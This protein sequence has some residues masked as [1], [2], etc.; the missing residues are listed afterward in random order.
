MAGGGEEVLSLM[1]LQ[2]LTVFVFAALCA[3][4]GKV[5]VGADFSGGGALPP[6]WEFRTHQS[7]APVPESSIVEDA[8]GTRFLRISEAKGLSGTA[9][10]PKSRF[11]AQEGDTVEIELV[12]RG[13][14]TFSV[15]FARYTASGAW[16][17]RTPE[18]I[19][20]LEDEWKRFSFDFPVKNSP[21]G[22]VSSLQF[23]IG[24]KKASE[25][26][27]HE[28]FVR[29][30]R[31]S[32]PAAGDIVVVNKLS[33]ESFESDGDR[34]GNPQVVKG[35][36]APGIP[37]VIRRGRY[38]F[39]SPCKAKL[40]V[41][42]FT[43]PPDCE[44]E[45]FFVF[46]ARVYSLRDADASFVFGVE[47]GNVRRVPFPPLHEAKLPADV[48]YA[49]DRDGSC[50][51]TLRSLADL[52]VVRKSG[53][54]SFFDGLDLP[55]AA[56]IDLVPHNGC[57]GV[58]ELDEIH[59]CYAKNAE[60]KAFPYQENP[61]DRFDPEKSGWPLVF[62]DDFD[63]EKIDS[64]KWFFPPWR[65][66][67]SDLARLDGKGNLVI[68]AEPDFEK[69]GLLRTTGIWTKRS[70]RYGYFEARVKFT[71]QPGWWAA[72]WLY[73]ICNCNPFLDG[74]EID[75]FE[76]YPTRRGEYVIS[77]NLHNNV[78][79]EA[80]KSWG[81]LS[82]IPAPVDG[83]HVFGCKWTPFGI[84]EYIDGK[85][86][87]SRGL[88]SGEDGGPVV[89][90]GLETVVG[91]V[92][93]HVVFSGTV[94]KSSRGKID[95]SS[96]RYPDEF[97]VD[98][99]KVYAWPDAGKG[100]KIG[101]KDMCEVRRVT[102]GETLK[103]DL[104]VGSLPS[105]AKVKNVYLLDNGYPVAFRS[106]PPWEF[107][108]PFSKEYYGSTQYMTPGR[109]GVS[110][111]FDGHVHAYVAFAEDV[112]GVVSSTGP[113]LRIPLSM[114]DIKPWDGKRLGLVRSAQCFRYEY[115]ARNGGVR[116]LSLKYAA[117]PELAFDNRCYV[118]LDGNL[119]AQLQ[120]K[121]TE[122]S[123]EFASAIVKF[124]SG[125]HEL[126]FIPVGIFTVYALEVK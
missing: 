48:V 29:R 72:F 109:S 60:A 89:F 10:G 100:P 125:R 23:W 82:T 24:A 102:P 86:I 69:E 121:C 38:R 15:S 104:Q 32:F 88:K 28:I 77:H 84:S 92:P 122:K 98:W 85:L 111:P 78:P 19:A 71:F 106:E 1:K 25:L 79:Y 120:L 95:F 118:L 31:S 45:Q 70:F 20:K 54:D 66:K 36:F 11:P 114:S 113:L 108:I 51:M 7:F 73:G 103:F 22:A 81:M 55:F 99:V 90:R 14:G 49:V 44:R 13:R 75:M 34:P 37:K 42:R 17:W 67:N 6:D 61:Q 115:D 76:D 58:A 107:E 119:V 87:R 3:F 116:T 5:D 47:R 112:N 96:H 74:F 94:S 21:V 41:K 26:D 101:W 117:S 59:A 8:D 124:P 91:T 35:D 4:A 16:A 12:V 30:R 40:P 52:S 80:A 93:L 83:Y 110:P 46:G 63:G 56:A 53:Y 39:D 18:K 27:V 43:L 9:L 68:S 126:M 65:K 33:E 62:L 2:L 50:T 105:G 64:A 97:V 57:R 123:T